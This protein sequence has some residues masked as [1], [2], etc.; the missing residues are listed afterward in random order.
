M[1]E[2]RS[3]HTSHA[4][5]NASFAYCGQTPWLQRGTIRQ[6]I[7]FGEPL[8]SEWLVDVVE[9]C[10]LAFDLIE[11]PLALDTE[12]GESGSCLSGGQKAR[13][14]LARAVYQRADVYLFDDPLAALDTQVGHAVL[15]RCLGCH[16]LL[17]GRTRI[18]ATHLPDWL[19]DEVIEI[20]INLALCIERKS[21]RSGRPG[22]HPRSGKN[23]ST[24][25]TGPSAS[26]KGLR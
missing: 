2:L 12:V 9:A 1:G 7:L 10:G 25:V 17:A 5:L 22:D 6:N 18:V 21:W 15:Q 14:A 13:V 19:F 23:C 3:N 4:T 11:M 16:G 8:D 20:S 26:H 24:M